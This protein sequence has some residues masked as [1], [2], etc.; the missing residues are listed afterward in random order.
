MRSHEQV[1]EFTVHQQES[2]SPKVPC[3]KMVRPPPRLLGLALAVVLTVIVLYINLGHH[4]VRLDS[5]SPATSIDDLA[6]V[7]PDMQRGNAIMGHLGNE[8]L[9]ADLGRAAWKL[10]HTTMARFPDQPSEEESVALKSYIYLFARL[11][12]CGE[13]TSHF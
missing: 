8:T 3:H 1:T 9:K 4:P 11:Y 10:F 13:C 6:H 7:S 5:N 12:P 2:I